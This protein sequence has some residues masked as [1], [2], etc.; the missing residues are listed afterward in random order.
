MKEDMEAIQC[1]AL[2]NPAL[3]SGWSR[4]TAAGIFEKG[5]YS[6]REF[7]LNVIDS[8]PSCIYVTDLDGKLIF[9][10]DSWAKKY[11]IPKEQALGRTI[12]DFYAKE[13]GDAI[14]ILD[15]KVI[16][17]GVSCRF[18]ECLPKEGASA[19]FLST[20]FPI[21]DIQGNIYGVGGVIADITEFKR[22]E[23]IIKYQANLVANISDAIISTDSHRLIKMLRDDR[24]NMT[25]FVGILHNITER[26]RAEEQLSWNKKS[27]QLLAEVTEQLLV[28]DR[29]LEK[30]EELCHRVMKFL[31]CQAFLHYLLDEEK[32]SLSLHATA[33]I[34]QE[35]V[36]EIVWLGN[37]VTFEDITSG[38][39]P[40]L[41]AERISE[42]PKLAGL[43]YCFGIRNYA[44]YP[45]FAQN[46][47]IGILAF[48]SRM[49][50]SFAEDEL[51]LMKA[52]T[53][54]VAVAMNRIR[55]E[56]ILVESEK[57][58]RIL[59]EELHQADQ[60]KDQFLAVL[61]HELRNPLAIIK[62]CLAV[63]NYDA[64]REEQAGRAGEVANRQIDHLGH[65]VDDLLDI[66]RINQNKIHLYLQRLELNELV[67]RTLEDH[68]PFFMKKGISLADD[69]W[70]TALFVEADEAR[71]SQV[72]GNLLTNAAKFTASG[73]GTRVK[74]SVAADRSQAVVRVADTGIGMEPAVLDRLFQPFMQADTSLDWNR[75]GLGLGLALSKGLLALHGG[76]ISASSAGL[77][78]GSEFVICLPLAVS[79][80]ESAPE[81]LPKFIRQ[82]RRVLIID[83]NVDLAH[84]LCDLLELYEHEV[85]VAYNGLEGLAQAREFRPE[86][87][88]CDI[89]LPGMD[90]YQVAKAFRGDTA[91]RNVFLVALT[92]YAQAAD[93]ERVIAAGFE[94]HL[95]KPV[96]LTTLERLLAQ[97]PGK[98][99]AATEKFARPRE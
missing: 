54:Q 23:E 44:F 97:M 34:P 93:R 4:E 3:Q 26:K 81:S 89:G 50:D 82:K 86:V 29:P 18:Q 72:L 95:A 71:L 46:R 42:M 98:T 62:N 9:I 36:R 37:D 65:L 68:R 78:Q 11:G 53:D 58:Y 30:I 27:G 41:I 79:L 19:Y 88:L 59:A 55:T 16:A 87:L 74:V 10:N 31:D 33:G 15:Q 35:I 96:D 61:S 13:D 92:G 32:Q 63:L 52:V 47:L 20:K 83:D 38:A 43:L 45:M 28:I 40:A 1:A 56:K 77:G 5:L 80:P 64:A 75:G 66:T 60:R 69:L 84:S 90:G 25:G 8:T 67:R 6:S 57:R 70:Q 12:Y 22:A 17:E 24:G 73:G 85:K 51:S 48:G 39:G 94:C 99:P 7:F 49:K 91:L 21:R 14:D 2:Q 76:S